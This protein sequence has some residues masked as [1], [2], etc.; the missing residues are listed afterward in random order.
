M[1]KPI[2]PFTAICG[3]DDFKLA[4]LLCMIDPS[5]GGV[6]A[7][8]DKGTGKTT[9]VRAL[10]SLM[11]NIESHSFYVSLNTKSTMKFQTFYKSRLAL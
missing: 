10:Q 2:F 3:Q 7:L 11:K 8:G 9:T 4:L 5:L 6:L 1:N